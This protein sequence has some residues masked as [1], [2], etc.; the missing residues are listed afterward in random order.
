MN[1]F[2]S[3]ILALEKKQKRNVSEGRPRPN[4]S[5]RSGDKYP[6]GWRT[7]IS[8]NFSQILLRFWYASPADIFFLGSQTTFTT[9]NLD[10]GDLR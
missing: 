5:E 2:V 3:A 9:K 7:R 10:G 4:F 8:M 6:P 1:N